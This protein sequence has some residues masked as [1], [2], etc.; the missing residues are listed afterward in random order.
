MKHKWTDI[1]ILAAILSVSVNG[2]LISLVPRSRL[3]G[4]TAKRGLVSNMS[5]AISSMYSVGAMPPLFACCGLVLNFTVFHLE[6]SF[7]YFECEY[8]C[9]YTHDCTYCSVYCFTYAYFPQAN[10]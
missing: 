7:L 8:L 1:R 2:A 6:C 10:K 5:E 4:S 9:T 3:P